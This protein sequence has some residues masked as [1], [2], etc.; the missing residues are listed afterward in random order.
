MM[1]IAL[2]D[3]TEVQQVRAEASLPRQLRCSRQ[4]DSPAA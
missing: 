3:F 2:A 4:P 1:E